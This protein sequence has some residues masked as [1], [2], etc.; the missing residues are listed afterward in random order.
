MPQP[1]VGR[2]R[3]RSGSKQADCATYETFE[4]RLICDGGSLVKNSVAL[5]VL[6]LN[7]HPFVRVIGKVLRLVGISSPEDTLIKPAAAS[8]P[9]SWRKPNP[10]LVGAKELGEETKPL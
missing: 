1:F 9:P 2:V 4:E 3:P 6:R 10:P 7:M 5:G 8:D